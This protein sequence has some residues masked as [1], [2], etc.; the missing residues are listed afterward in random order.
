[1]WL[2]GRASFP[3]DASLTHNTLVAHPS[4]GEGVWVDAHVTAALVNDLFAG[5]TVGITNTAPASSTLS[6]DHNLFWNASDPI[7][8]VNAVRADP[9]LDATDHLTDGSPARDAGA[10]VDVTTDVDGDPRPVGAY[11]IGA[12]EYALRRFLPLLVKDYTEDK[13]G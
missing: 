13:G 1:V 9:Q 10:A 4:G 5:H 12:D 8:G 6:V 3:V 11:D 2:G 7:V